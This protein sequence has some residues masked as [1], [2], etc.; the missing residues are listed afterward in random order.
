MEL[1]FF[2]E[3]PL[4][5]QVLFK[6]SLSTFRSVFSKGVKLTL[7]FF[8]RRLQQFL[9]LFKQW[10]GSRLM[11]SQ[12]QRWM[13]QQRNSSRRSP[14]PIRASTDNE[15][16]SQLKKNGDAIN[17]VKL[18]APISIGTYYVLLFW[19]MASVTSRLWNNTQTRCVVLIYLFNQM[20]KLGRILTSVAQIICFHSFQS[21][22]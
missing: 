2:S 14:W 5:L 22:I 17:P 11:S 12:E 10:Q 7:L 18:V 3:H 16:S 9:N 1:F 4:R 15:L 20:V 6:L 13:Q 19:G 21:I 8:I